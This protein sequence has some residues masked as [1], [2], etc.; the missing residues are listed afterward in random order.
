MLRNFLFSLALA[1]GL[2]TAAA[3]E[4]TPQALV[5]RLWDVMDMDAMMPILRDEAVAEAQEMQQTMLP[6]AGQSRWLNRV[7][8]IHDPDRMADLFRT[9]MIEA[10]APTDLA[11]LDAALAL[12]ETPL[13]Q[14]L[15]RLESSARIA[16]MDEETEQDARD[17]FAAAASTGE[18]RVQQIAQLI[19]VSDLIGAN[20]AGGM[21]A[22]IAFSRGFADGG[23]FDMPPPE[24][25]MLA[26]AWAQEPEL[27]AE[28]LGWMEAYLMLA[29]S[30]LSDRELRQYIDFA[31]S[32]EGQAL[33]ALLFAGF[34][35][36]FR[37]TS[38][39]LGLAAAGEMQG[40][41]L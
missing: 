22:A 40:Q 9:G 3:A 38:Y 18:A 34:E 13:G 31:G 27:R 7:A 16:L 24:A 10:V 1:T 36:L 28:T 11:R 33:S 41:T 30:P 20:V 26:D 6:Q 14:R 21:N 15:I 2:V 19:E 29:Y 23:G 4:P 37:Q 5:D 17:R 32:D 8:K 39:D 12:Y 25:Q 35:G